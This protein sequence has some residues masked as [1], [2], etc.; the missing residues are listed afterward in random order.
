[1]L[2]GFVLGHEFLEGLELMQSQLESGLLEE[3]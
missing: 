1:M 2:F 3:G